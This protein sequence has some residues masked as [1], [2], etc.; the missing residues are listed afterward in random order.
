M[1]ALNHTHSYIKHKSRPKYYK[2]SHPDCTHTAHYD[3][4]TGKRSMCGCGETF[5][6]NARN[7]RLRI[8]HCGACTKGFVP[9]PT[10]SNDLISQ[11][12]GKF[13]EDMQDE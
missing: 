1:A 6:L 9:K 13:M 4:I 5:I 8:P 11:R 3:D 12:L 7:L 10:I 2:C